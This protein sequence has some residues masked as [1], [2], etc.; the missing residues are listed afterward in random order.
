VLKRMIVAG[1]VGAFLVA[2]PAIAKSSAT[3][4]TKTPT[5]KVQVGHHGQCPSARTA[6]SLG[7]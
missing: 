3:V 1:L 2:P 4:V 7:L 5:A 6:T